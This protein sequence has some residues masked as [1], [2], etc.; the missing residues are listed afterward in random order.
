MTIAFTSLPINLN[1][2]VGIPI[3]SFYVTGTSTA[4]PFSAITLTIINNP[5]PMPTGL[6][7]TASTITGLQTW[8]SL[9]SGTPS[10]PGIYFF[11]IQAKDA[12]DSIATQ[13]AAMFITNNAPPQPLP[14]PTP[15]PTPVPINCPCVN[16]PNCP[17]AKC[18]KSICPPPTVASGSG[19]SIRTSG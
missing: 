15:T 1:A 17:C 4:I 2:P 16:P 3:T 18:A 14:I 9:L 13:N 12:N 7:L 6:S 11:T 10:V 19:M 8:D 5:N